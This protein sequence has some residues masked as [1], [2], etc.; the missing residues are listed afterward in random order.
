MAH[1]W[2]LK[3]SHHHQKLRQLLAAGAFPT[4]QPGTVSLVDVA[5]DA[6]CGI[7]KGRR[8]HCDPDI[9]LRFTVGSPN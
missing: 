9:R 4:I 1:R 2:K 8:C 7:F 3:G 6:W 5:H